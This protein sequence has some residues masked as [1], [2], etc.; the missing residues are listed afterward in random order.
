MPTR[1]EFHSRF[2]GSLMAFGLVETLWQRDLF[3]DA[4]KPTIQKWILDLVALTKDLKGTKLTDLQ[5]QTKMEELYKTVDLKELCGLVKLDEIEKKKLPENGA[6]SSVRR[7][8]AV[9]G[10]RQRSAGTSRRMPHRLEADA[11]QGTGDASCRR[12]AR[13]QSRP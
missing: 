3:A 4:V 11:F 6:S 10:S 1:R 5:F 2:L 7:R 9:S 13:S 12:P 8:G